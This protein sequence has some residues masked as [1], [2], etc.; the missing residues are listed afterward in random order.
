[1]W[2]KE[3]PLSFK[4]VSWGIADIMI[5][6]ARGGKEDSCRLILCAIL[7]VA[8]INALLFLGFKIFKEI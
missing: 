8:Y 1:M 2:S 4:K 3:I 5:G 6:F 7:L